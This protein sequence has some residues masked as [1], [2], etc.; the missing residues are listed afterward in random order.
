MVETGQG[1]NRGRSETGKREYH[2]Q[3]RAASDPLEPLV[4][5]LFQLCLVVAYQWL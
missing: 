1:W 4:L 2:R 5:V 3:R